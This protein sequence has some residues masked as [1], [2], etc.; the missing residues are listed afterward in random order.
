MT[1]SINEY[2]DLNNLAFG[3][4]QDVSQDLKELVKVASIFMPNS[5]IH[6]WL[7]DT[8]LEEVVTDLNLRN[9]L[10]SVITNTPIVVYHHF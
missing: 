8:R 5:K 7:I 6:K 1:I 3:L 10:K 9:E 4:G 2:S